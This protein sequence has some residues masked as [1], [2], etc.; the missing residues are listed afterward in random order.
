MNKWK[1]EF[2][3]KVLRSCLRGSTSSGPFLLVE[4]WPEAWAVRA[5]CLTGSM[6]AASVTQPIPS[7]KYAYFP[8][9]QSS[10]LTFYLLKR[11]FIYK[12]HT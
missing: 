5:R 4:P 2:V 9:A 10:T 7:S 12:R 8:L 6:A 11:R 3:N 1:V